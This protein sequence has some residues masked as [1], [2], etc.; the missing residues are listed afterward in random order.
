MV[1]ILDNLNSHKNPQF[2]EYVRSKGVLLEYSP[3]YSSS[4]NAI[5]HAWS[6]LKTAW[7]RFLVR[8]TTT[9]NRSNLERD[10]TK[11]CY[12]L[13]ITP[14]LLAHQQRLFDDVLLGKIA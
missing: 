9:Y 1:V 13:N 3:R 11:M 7:R 12:D 2:K 6:S 14:A 5:E 10:I 4:L 8:Q